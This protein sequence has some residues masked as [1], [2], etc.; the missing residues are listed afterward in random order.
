[1]VVVTQVGGRMGMVVTRVTATVDTRTAMVAIQVD[2]Q[3]ET[4]TVLGMETV[5]RLMGMGFQD[6]TKCL[7]FELLSERV[8]ELLAK[9]C[10]DLT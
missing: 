9:Y 10:E 8:L 3:T 7:G 1:M 6:R 5:T 4:A 2:D